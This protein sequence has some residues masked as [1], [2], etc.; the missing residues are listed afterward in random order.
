LYEVNLNDNN[1]EIT[2]LP[3]TLTMVTEMAY[4]A[5]YFHIKANDHWFTIEAGTGTAQVGGSKLSKF[6]EIVQRYKNRPVNL[7][8]FKKVVN[9]GYTTLNTVKS[10]YINHNGHLGFDDRHVALKDKSQMIFI[11]HN[12]Q[13]RN[14]SWKVHKAKE[15]DPP[16]FDIPNSN[17]KFSKFVWDDGSE[18]LADS[19]GLLHLRSSD[20][21]IPEITIVNIMGRPTACWAADGRVYGSAYFT[22]VDNA[23]NKD[24]TGFYYNY[25][26]RFI[27][28][29]KNHGANSKV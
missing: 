6:D 28:T 24:V 10:V 19:R 14:K 7:S 5:G 11:E 26:Q 27:D 8:H 12:A 18:V 1:A 4:D 17:L 3:E 22:G 20:N 25:I 29:V 23:E 15:V 16:L 21:S 2:K 13:D 9:D